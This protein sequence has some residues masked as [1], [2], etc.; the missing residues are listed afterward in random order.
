[1][2]LNVECNPCCGVWMVVQGVSWSLECG[3]STN[4][5]GEYGWLTNLVVECGWLTNLVVECGWLT[6]L[7]AK[8]GWLTKLVVE[9][10]LVLGHYGIPCGLWIVDVYLWLSYSL[11]FSLLIGI[12]FPLGENMIL[13]Y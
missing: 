9:C 1:M 13:S 12:H 2:S 7:V 5:V 4:L 10:G 6:K 8:C 3:W 11:D